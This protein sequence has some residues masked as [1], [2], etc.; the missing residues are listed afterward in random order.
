MII[1]LTQ[2]EYDT[3]YDFSEKVVETNLDCYA[4]R[5]QF[6]RDKIVDDIIV[7]KLA[8]VACR[9][10][11]IARGMVPN[12][13]DFAIY[14][15]KK[16]SF[17]SDLIARVG[18]GNEWRFHVKCMKEGTASRFGLSWSFQVQDSLVTCAAEND[19]LMLCQLNDYFTV[20]VKTVTLARNVSGCWKDP[21]LARL[22]GIKKVLY[23]SD[24]EQLDNVK[25]L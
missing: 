13:V 3:C 17:D 2:D 9:K 12:D 23:W 16:K 20:D 25:K 19:Y 7:G 21:K 18:E 1:K 8:E 11:L 24:L 5:Q 4:R 14:G 22:F 10:L 6:D 15:K